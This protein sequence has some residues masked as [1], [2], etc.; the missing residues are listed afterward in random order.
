MSHIVT[1]TT[2]FRNMEILK[3]A[4][5]KCGAEIEI[6][7]KGQTLS[8]SLYGG[9]ATGIAAIKLKGW[10]YPVIVQ[11]DGTCLGDNYGGAWGKQ[12]ELDALSVQYS[13]ELV[14]S[15]LRKQGY[16]LQKEYIEEDGTQELVFVC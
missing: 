6:A 5:A 3:K 12:E 16:R 4:A 10:K 1:I 9:K 2:S 15:N 13:K 14:T 11:E 8:R 7:E